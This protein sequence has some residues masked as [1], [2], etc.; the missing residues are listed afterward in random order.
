MSSTGC[1]PGIGPVTKNEQALSGIEALIGRR[2]SS[3]HAIDL[4]ARFVSA[5]LNI[6]LQLD[7]ISFTG[8][9]ARMLQPRDLGEGRLLWLD[10]ECFVQVVWQAEMQCGF[11]FAERLEPD[12]LRRTLEFGDLRT[13]K[14]PG[15]LHKLASAWV[16]G[17][18][19]Y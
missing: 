5:D 18:G 3:R 1:E 4:A 7:D 15:T 6:R 19:D 13:S 16:Y 8:A 17:P 10:Y 14:G 12:Q 9:S 2:K 11:R